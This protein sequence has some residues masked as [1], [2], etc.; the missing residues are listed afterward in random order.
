MPTPRRT[1]PHLTMMA[2]THFPHLVR[3][4][5]TRL[6]QTRPRHLRRLVAPPLPIAM[7]GDGGRLMGG[8]GSLLSENPPR[9]CRVCGDRSRRMCGDG[10]ARHQGMVGNASERVAEQRRG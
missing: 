7:G 5:S 9:H 6:A 3:I 10:F 2:Q 8:N 1:P 4:R